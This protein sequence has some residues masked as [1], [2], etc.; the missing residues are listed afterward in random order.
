M[1]DVTRATEHH[2]WYPEAEARE[3]YRDD[4][5]D[6]R[7]AE[8]REKPVNPLPGG[9]EFAPSWVD[10]G[11][12]SPDYT[13]R[14]RRPQYG[15][16]KDAGLSD[17][18]LPPE[19]GGTGKRNPMDADAL[20]QR[21]RREAQVMGLP[22]VESF[23][24]ERRTTSWGAQYVKPVGSPTYRIIRDRKGNRHVYT[25]GAF[26]RAMRGK[27]SYL[28]K[29]SDPTGN[30]AIASVTG[31]PKGSAKVLIM[32]RGK[33]NMWLGVHKIL[34]ENGKI[35]DNGRTAVLESVIAGIPPGKAVSL[36]VYSDADLKAFRHVPARFKRGA[37]G[38]YIRFVANI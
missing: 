13:R 21:E 22:D 11:A 31:E 37:F 19:R 34:V 4:D 29:F 38:E 24:K 7:E 36:R 16:L 26:R 10:Y 35:D 3:H 27:L 20:A 17:A 28:K 12:V 6:R 14:Q 2:A 33:L 5:A 32:T 8:A 30:A 1:Y 15:D 9:D 25:Q 23:T 18:F